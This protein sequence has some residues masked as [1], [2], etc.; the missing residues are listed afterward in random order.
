M[1]RS[2]STLTVPDIFPVFSER[3]HCWTCEDTDRLAKQKILLKKVKSSVPVLS[4]VTA[5]SEPPLSLPDETNDVRE[6]K[7]HRK[8]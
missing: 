2:L 1:K 7:T 6:K 3:T 4:I 8:I 5:G